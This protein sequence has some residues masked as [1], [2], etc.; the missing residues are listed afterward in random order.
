LANRGYLVRPFLVEPENPSPAR[1]L[2]LEI[3]HLDRVVKGLE[4]VVHGIDGTA[5]TLS[6]LPIAGKTGT[7]QVARLQ[8]DVKPEDVERR[9]RHHAWFV[10]WA[11]LDNPSLVVAVLVEHG[12]GGGPVAAPIA[13]Q[14][15]KAH[16]ESRS[17][18]TI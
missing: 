7:A 11:P 17:G 9:L 14:L 1:F 6:D 16:L 18:D 13:G 3:D 15:L 8:D 4:D 2:D 5:R 12:G 10:G